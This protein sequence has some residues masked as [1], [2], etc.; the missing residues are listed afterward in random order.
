MR[1][2]A[3][4]RIHALS[5][6]GLFTLTTT[7]SG[8]ALVD[9]FSPRTKDFNT[10]T[11][12]SKSTAVLI[13]IMRSAYSKPLQFTDVSTV[14]G[15]SVITGGLSSTSL[16]ISVRGPTTTQNWTIGPSVT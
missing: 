16:P 1:S 10:E 9:Q 6:V 14:S 2:C 7:I 13:N 11:A 4:K 8:C 15:Q 3:Q 12:D 5:L